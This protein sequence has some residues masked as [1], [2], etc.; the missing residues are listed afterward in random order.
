MRDPDSEVINN[1]RRII[2]RCSKIATK[3]NTPPWVLPVYFPVS[4]PAQKLKLQD[5]LIKPY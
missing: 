3:K 4:R 2:N 1:H 5:T